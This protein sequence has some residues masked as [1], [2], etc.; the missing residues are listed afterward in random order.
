MKF[1]DQHL[2]DLTDALY[3]DAN[4]QRSDGITFEQLKLQL[5]KHDGLLESLSI[6]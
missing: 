1:S 5:E 4:P 6:K 2:D 3:E